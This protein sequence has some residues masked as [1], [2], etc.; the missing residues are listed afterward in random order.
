[1]RLLLIAACALPA[2]VL[3]DDWVEAGFDHQ[4]YTNSAPSADTQ[5]LAATHRDKQ[6]VIYGE[7]LQYQRFGQ[8]D[9]QATAG[10]YER[11][12]PTGQL[13]LE[14]SLAPDAVIKPR[15][16]VYAGW[17]QAL[18]GGWAVEPGA[19]ATRYATVHVERYSLNVE[20]YVGNWRFLY[21]VADVHLADSTALNQRVQTDWFYGERSR[22]GIGYGQGDDQES[23]PAGVVKTA[24]RS[25]F[26][27]GQHELGQRLSLI[28]Q[29][30]Q[31]DQGTLYTQRGG[32]L[33]IRVIF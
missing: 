28:W 27:A 19:Q 18:P 29:L 21:G 7:A 14:T 9:I 1:M 17:Y 10:I 22:V 15:S 2:P 33:G 24:V 13:H 25:E 4:R 16:N 31:T 32:R 23:L 8:T 5:Y 30:Q 12:T 11:L 20:K 6:R 3:A 26:I